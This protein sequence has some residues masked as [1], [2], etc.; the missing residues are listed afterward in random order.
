MIC[1]VTAKAFISTVQG[2]YFISSGAIVLLYFLPVSFN[3]DFLEKVFRDFLDVASGMFT[4]NNIDAE[5]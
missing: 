4:E 3:H 2:L 1:T 5:A